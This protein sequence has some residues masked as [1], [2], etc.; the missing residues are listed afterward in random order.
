[1]RPAALLIV[2]LLPARPVASS[3]QFQTGQVCTGVNNSMLA[4]DMLR[5]KHIVINELEWAPFATKD[6]DGVWSGMDIE[7]YTQIC[8]ILGCTYEVRDMGMP[9]EGG[10][11]TEVLLGELPNADLTGSWWLYTEE[12]FNAGNFLRGHV[13][14]ATVL[15]GTV[16]SQQ[17]DLL[18]RFSRSF[19][20]FLLP[21]DYWL[22]IAIFVMVLFSGSVDFFLERARVPESRWGSSVYEYCAGFLWGGF[23]YPQSKTSS[24]YQ[25][26][27]G[28]AALVLISSYTAQLAAHMTISARPS[29]SVV[30]MDDAVING[31]GTSGLTHCRPHVPLGI[32]LCVHSSHH[33]AW[34]LPCVSVA[35]KGI[36]SISYDSTWSRKVDRQGPYL[37]QCHHPPSR[38]GM[39]GTH[40][41]E[42]RLHAYVRYMS[43]TGGAHLPAP[44]VHAHLD[45][46][47]RPRRHARRGRLGLRG[48]AHHHDR[49]PHLPRR[50]KVL[51]VYTQGTGTHTC[52]CL[53]AYA[54]AGLHAC[55]TQIHTYMRS[56]HGP[57][58]PG[59]HP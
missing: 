51:Q 46:P 17:K 27:I 9:A 39:H 40:L 11:W 29:N 30:S 44:H 25:L 6:A 33:L 54:T 18:T 10:T 7:F 13:D 50:P 58:P 23:E 36:C 4:R 59:A 20:S 47:V 42:S 41:T 45:Q 16:A 3:A 55:W 14:I 1:M 48:H 21:F 57:V 5:G 32:I 34:M 56:R 2:L 19:F 49:L 12:R 31:K 22:W 53:R 15:V 35:G 52:A 24:I 37:T 26:F 38:N 8:A 43:V 28:F